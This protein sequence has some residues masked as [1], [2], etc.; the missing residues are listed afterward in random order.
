MSVFAS[1]YFD[2]HEHVSF[3][4]DEAS[5]LRAITAIHSTAPFGI[6]G[7]GCRMYPYASD[8]D[9]LRDA[10][11]LSRHMSYKLALCDIPSGGAKTVVIGD[12]ARDKTEAL[13]KALG[14]AVERLGGHYV[15]AED[16]GTTPE[17]MRIIGTETRYVVGR[18]TDTGP[19]TAYGTFV[20]LQ[21]SVERALGRKDLAG[22]RVAV[23]GL[24]NV[25][26]RLCKH[27]ASAG[28]KLVVTD[29]NEGAV[30]AVVS[31]LGATAVAPD[32]I[33]SQDVDVLAPCALGAIL[34]DTTIPQLRCKVIVGSANNQLA[35]DRHGEV[36][37]KMGIFYA[38]D[39]V[40]NAGGV[41][42]AGQEGAEERQAL[43]ETERVG[44]I[45]T[46]VFDLAQ[47]EGLSP[48][49]AAI[50]MARDKVRSRRS[51]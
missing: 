23:Q 25:G 48:N 13:L 28:A 44:T 42:G 3:F 6:S 46:A 43:K 31:E 18:Q 15:I 51:Q 5:G 7:G 21:A 22:L 9:A 36:L 29:V 12:P 50:R 35:E 10:L 38:P 30:R 8:E 41:I 34:N 47:K 20:A 40:T 27:L 2:N 33:L 4:T 1:P 17:D 39:F 26:R 32:A 19:T 45:L 14:R 49:A 37:A 11:R 24:G 16:V